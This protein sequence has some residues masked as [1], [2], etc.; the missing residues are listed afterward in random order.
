VASDIKSGLMTQVTT[1][2]SNAQLL[3]TLCLVSFRSV[4]NG[5]PGAFIFELARY[6][7][8][9]RAMLPGAKGTPFSLVDREPVGPSTVLSEVSNCTGYCC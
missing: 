4:G 6:K 9:T 3:M 5:A 8:V 2:C 1:S 7:P